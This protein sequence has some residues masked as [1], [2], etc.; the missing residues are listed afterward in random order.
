LRSPLLVSN[1]VS[2][3]SVIGQANANQPAVDTE[4][5][6]KFRSLPKIVR[7]LSRGKTGQIETKDIRL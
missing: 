1:E 6:R 7:D 3:T 5:L 4:K 2:T